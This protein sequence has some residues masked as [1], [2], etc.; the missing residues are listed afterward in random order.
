MNDSVPPMVDEPCKRSAAA[1]LSTSSHDA[2]TPP[3]WMTEAVVLLSAWWSKGLVARL[4]E[5][6]RLLRRRAGTF[7]LVDFALVLLCCQV[8]RAPTTKAFYEQAKSVGGTLASVWERA[9]WPSRSAL[10]RALAAVTVDTVESFRALFLAS[11][12]SVCRRARW[13]GFTTGEANGVS[14]STPMARGRRCG[15]AL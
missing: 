2:L 13:V 1:H 14:S 12:S 10:S 3:A 8:S 4:V 5:R 9:A 15:S 11:W 7:E 6:V